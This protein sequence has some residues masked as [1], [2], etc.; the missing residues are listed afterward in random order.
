MGVPFRFPGDYFDSPADILVILGIVD[1]NTLIA[2]FPVGTGIPIEKMF[3][4]DNQYPVPF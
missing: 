1:S 4:R 2:V 3:S